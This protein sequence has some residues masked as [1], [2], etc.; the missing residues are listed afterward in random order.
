MP[1][2]AEFDAFE[3]Y[4]AEAK[5]RIDDRLD[6]IIETEE[7]FAGK[8]RIL[9]HAAQGGKRVRPVLT[10]LVVTAIMLVFVM[11]LPILGIRNFI[12]TRWFAFLYVPMAILGAIGLRYLAIAIPPRLLVGVLLAFAIAYPAAML[13][14]PQA[15]V[16]NPVFED[17]RPELSYSQAELAGSR[18]VSDITG[19]PFP[20]DI[21][22]DQV[23]FT[24]HP[25][26][27]V[28]E[29]RGSHVTDA[30][31][32]NGSQ[33]ATHDITVYR[34]AQSTEATFFT[35]D[36]RPEV[37]NV[38]RERVCRPSQNVLYDNGGVVFCTVPD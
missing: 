22:P 17:V 6:E 32:L 37:M 13:V 15:T 7:G 2:Q 25:Y 9:S 34:R 10:M 19:S 11:G 5:Q 38:P 29:R 26:Q 36:G 21:R 8:R 27:T 3:E 4:Y 30:V 16:E 24:D 35:F 28:I 12:P 31:D 1:T 18:A 14:S 20:N 33:P 23:V